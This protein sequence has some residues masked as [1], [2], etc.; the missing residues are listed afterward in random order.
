MQIMNLCMQVLELMG[1]F[2]MEASLIK[3]IFMTNSLTVP[4]RFQNL[5]RSMSYV[6]VADEAFALRPDFLKPFNVRVLDDKK[7]IFNYRLSRARREIE[8]VFGILVS[9]FGVFRSQINLKPEN[10]DKVVTQFFKKKCFAKLLSTRT[11]RP[12][13]TSFSRDAR[14]PANR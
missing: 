11:L 9:R 1:E 10:I 5:A 8:N 6:F 12:R 3:F 7:R 2:Q 13:G 14:R 4:F